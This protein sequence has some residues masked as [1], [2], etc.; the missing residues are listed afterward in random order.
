MNEFKE[1]LQLIQADTF[2]NKDSNMRRRR[3]A[4]KSSPSLLSRSFSLE[5]RIYGNSSSRKNMDP[6]VFNDAIFIQF[7]M[8]SLFL[9][10]KTKQ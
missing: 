8:H 10:E 2:T 4:E 6:L 5:P 1:Q 9:R 3:I 7:L